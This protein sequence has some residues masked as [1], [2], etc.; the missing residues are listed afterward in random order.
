MNLLTFI[1]FSTGFVLGWV[2][3]NRR[4]KIKTWIKTKLRKANA[5]ADNL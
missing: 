2:A 1:V 5:A 3:N 4:V